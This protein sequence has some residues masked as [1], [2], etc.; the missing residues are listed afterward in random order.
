MT[1]EAGRIAGRARRCGNLSNHMWTACPITGGRVGWSP[2]AEPGAGPG[3]PLVGA[4]R[5]DFSVHDS[6]LMYGKIFALLSRNLGW[7]I[8][9]WKT[10]RALR[11]PVL[12]Q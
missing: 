2:K 5:K 8:F 9:A 12:G 6:T 10:C 3:R 4:Q 11:A 1:R 7:R